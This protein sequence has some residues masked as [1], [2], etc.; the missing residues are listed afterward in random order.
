[1]RQRLLVGILALGCMFALAAAPGLRAGAA[2]SPT[3]TV[4]NTNE[5]PPDGVWFRNSPHIADTD[6]VT[7]HGVYA[8][9]QV[10]LLCYAWGDAVG[11]HH[12]TLWYNVV[13]VTRP[14][15]N[16]VSNSGYLNAHYI[17][18][19]LAANQVDAGVPQ[20]GS[21]PPPPPPSGP[22]FTVMNT[23]E[24]PPD[25]VWFRNSPHSADTDRV[26]GHGVYMNEQVQL[27]C[28][29]WGDAVGPYGNTLWYDV[30][31]VTRPTNNGVSNSGYLNAHYINDGL[32]ANQIDAGVPQCGSSP[33]PPPAGGASVYYS[34]AGDA[35][36]DL[37]S[38]Y[39]SVIMTDNGSHGTADWS[40]GQCST[41]WSNR[42]PDVVGGR[43]VTTLSGW[44]LGRLGPI[45]LLARDQSKASNVNYVLMFDPGTYGELAGG[46]DA[47]VGSSQV[48]ANWLASNASN[49][50]V[51]MSGALTQAQF[52]HGIQNVYFPA[53]RGHAIAQ[54]VLVCN[55]SNNG[56]GWSH[57]DVIKG[58]AW[59]ISQPAP[60]VCPSNFLGW[61]P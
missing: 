36:W 44:S 41:A 58:Y 11:S 3:F 8:N 12:N 57:R 5:T 14:T 19:G 13:N 18:D 34:G 55:V 52:S 35:G 38:P 9:E 42:Y 27:Q 25:G 47:T 23:S 53:I 48:L 28:Y 40:A 43:R 2:S 32:A 33:P 45:Y 30:T 59:M 61:H 10:Q 51:I 31:N 60:S 54:Q 46:C 39:A 15:N 50:L 21:S 17:N 49:R 20:C 7:G 37:A 26:T 4:M 1:M 6:R 16:G 24:S 29:S 22:I 56:V